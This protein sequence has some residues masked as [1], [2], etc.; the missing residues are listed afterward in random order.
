[1]FHS[2]AGTETTTAA[3]TYALYFLV[4]HP[5]T[6]ATLRAELDENSQL[7]EVM[8]VQESGKLPYLTAVL[9]EGALVAFPPSSPFVAFPCP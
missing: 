6:L 1:M 9:K 5:Q 7:D 3:L 8:G 4:T 2:L